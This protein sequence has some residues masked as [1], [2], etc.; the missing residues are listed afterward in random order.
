MDVGEAGAGRG[1]ARGRGGRRR[2]VVEGAHV[3]T[4]PGSDGPGQTWMGRV[5]R[6]RHDSQ[7]HGERAQAKHAALGGL[8]AAA[9]A[10]RRV[11]FPREMV[12]ALVAGGG[13]VE[14]VMCLLNLG[15]N[16]TCSG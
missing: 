13:I 8:R 11:C 6:A 15:P 3:R 9:S 12:L 4:R 2:G 5:P 7:D 14:S 16:Q 10:A 1:R